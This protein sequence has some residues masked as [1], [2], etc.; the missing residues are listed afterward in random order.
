MKLLIPFLM[1]ALLVQQANASAKDGLTIV[2]EANKAHAIGPAELAKLPR[3]RAKV[4]IHGEKAEFEGAPLVDVLKSVGVEFGGAQGK[5][6]ATTVVIEA[7]DDYRT[8]L[9]LLEID[10]ETTDTQAILADRRDGKPLG[11]NEGPYRL[12]I[13]DEKRPIRWIRMIRSMRVVN[14]RDFP[15]IPAKAE[16]VKA[17]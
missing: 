16:N 11:E 8:A 5:R 9:T 10:P 15:L 13:P 1:S 7:M 17:E 2:D 6:A 4:E 3:A 12:V 14:L